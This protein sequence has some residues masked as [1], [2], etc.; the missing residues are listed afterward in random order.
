LIALLVKWMS[1]GPVLERTLHAGKGGRHFN[2]LKFRTNEGENPARTTRIGRFLLRYRSDELPQL[3]NILRGKMS[4]VGPAPLPVGV[5]ETGTVS[6]EYAAW[7][8]TRSL[9]QPGLT[10]LWQ[11]SPSTLS[12]DDMVQ[13]DLEYIQSRSL[14]L[15]LSILLSTP[16]QVI[17]GVRMAEY[18]VIETRATA[19]SVGTLS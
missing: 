13:L 19:Q 9:I 12:F 10:G 15:D 18:P 1:N 3:A 7:Q 5:L 14:S 11:V 6:R 8:E 4:L 16:L 2:C 17:R